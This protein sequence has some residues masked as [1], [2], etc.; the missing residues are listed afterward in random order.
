MAGLR[1]GSQDGSFLNQ[2]LRK[3]SPEE[4]LHMSRVSIFKEFLQFLLEC[5][6]WWLIPIVTF[7]VLLGALLFLSQNP[8]I[9][10]FIYTI[11]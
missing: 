9:A 7:L 4:V 3:R 1:C 11:F 8:V 6:K 5:K 2:G 10:P